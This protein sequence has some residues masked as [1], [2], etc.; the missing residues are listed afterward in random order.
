MALIRKPPTATAPAVAV[1]LAKSGVP[2]FPVATTKAPTCPSGFKAASTDPEVVHDLWDRWPGP[3][4]GIATG[5]VS[6]IDV[7]DLDR[8][9]GAAAWWIENREKIPATRC[10]RTRS[11]GLHLLFRHHAGLRCSTAKIAPGV[12]VKAENGCVVWW[13]SAGLP[14]LADISLGAVAD[15]PNWLID[16]AKPSPK[17]AAPVYVRPSIPPDGT[18]RERYARAAL[19]NAADRVASAPAGSRNTTLNSMVFQ[20]AR[21][22]ADGTLDPQ[23]IADSLAVA[24]LATGLDRREV[25]AT[26]ASAM[27]AAGGAS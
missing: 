22:V 1:E 8:Q 20:L 13:P 16:L 5:S 15:W 4:V 17:A 14:V 11:G 19:C 24:A 23:D 10:H 21:F 25:I 12:D 7:L 27:R 2:V 3:L 9:H 26:I 6:G 18:R